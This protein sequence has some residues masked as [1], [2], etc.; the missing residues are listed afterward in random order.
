MLISNDYNMPTFQKIK[1]YLIHLE[2]MKGYDIEFYIP[3][4]PQSVVGHNITTD[5]LHDFQRISDAKWVVSTPST[6]CVC[7]SM[8]GRVRE[9]RIIHSQE[10]FDYRLK[11]DPNYWKDLFGEREDYKIWKLV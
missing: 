4:R 8:M 6:F 3:E 1:D 2:C 10:W 11:D 5:V 7:A 9:K